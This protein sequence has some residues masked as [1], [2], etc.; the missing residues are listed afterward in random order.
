M[1]QLGDCI[2][3]SCAAL[4]DAQLAAEVEADARS[5]AATVFKQ[6]VDAYQQAGTSSF[7]HSRA[8]LGIRGNQICL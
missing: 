5:N 4:P 1:Q 8:C 3:D 7:S 6:A 2:L